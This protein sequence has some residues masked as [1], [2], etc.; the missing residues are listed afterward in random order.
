MACRTQA[1]ASGRIGKNRPALCIGDADME[2]QTTARCMRQRFGHAAK[3]LSVALGYRMG[4]EL[5]KHIAVS[6]GQRMVVRIVDF[7]LAARVFMVHL[8]QAK[9]QGAQCHTHIV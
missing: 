6:S 7:I 1:Q 5:K 8:L 3:Y 2:M 4:R 9:T